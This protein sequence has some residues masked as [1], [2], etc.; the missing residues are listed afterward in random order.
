L[1]GKSE[2]STSHF[3]FLVFGGDSIEKTHSRSFIFTTEIDN[4]SKSALTLHENLFIEDKFFLKQ[5]LELESLPDIT[6]MSKHKDFIYPDN[7][8]HRFMGFIGQKAL[9]VFDMES[10]MWVAGSKPLGYQEHLI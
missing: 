10:R 1:E 5:T 8:P 4:F 3:E 2:T 6:A 9:H 7:K